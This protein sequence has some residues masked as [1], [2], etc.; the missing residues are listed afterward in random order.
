[1][2]LEP[3]TAWR[4]GCGVLAQHSSTI[5]GNKL[6][7]VGITQ[8]KVSLIIQGSATVF[9][10]D[11]NPL[12][13]GC[14]SDKPEQNRTEQRRTR[15]HSNHQITTQ[16]LECASRWKLR[17]RKREE[18]CTVRALVNYAIEFALWFVAIVLAL[19]SIVVVNYD[20]GFTR[21]SGG[22]RIAL[23]CNWR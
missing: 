15:T 11:R 2:S 4:L 13:N 14:W 22:E 3:W 18:I 20:Q 9:G 19:P 16:W 1:M 7:L 5:N 21:L 17:G 8:S 6:Y 12:R 23:N 10:V